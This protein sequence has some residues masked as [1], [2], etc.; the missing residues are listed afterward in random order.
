[1]YNKK[2]PI[3]LSCGV[4]VALEVM[5]GKWKSYIIYALSNGSMRPS[6]IHKKL[7]GASGRVIDQQLKELLDYGIVSKQDFDTV[8]KHTEY[9]L[10]DFGRTLLPIISEM[11]KWGTV[12]KPKVE[13]A[14][15]EKND[16]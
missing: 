3:D 16:L 5:G 9:S 2:M 7:P 4:K 14:I 12:Y 13:Q 6:E 1:M 8:P 10:T 11:D 15:V